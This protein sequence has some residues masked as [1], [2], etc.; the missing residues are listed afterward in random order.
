MV[1]LCEKSRD[2]DETWPSQPLL[3]SE[4]TWF[5]AV[6]N[7]IRID[8][9]TLKCK[10]TLRTHRYPS[11]MRDNVVQ[12]RC[13]DSWKCVQGLVEWSRSGLDHVLP[14]QIHS[15]KALRLWVVTINTREGTSLWV[16]QCLVCNNQIENNLTT[17]WLV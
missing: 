14:Q 11:Y 8:S 7:L 5:T 3:G 16:Q 15:L 17:V 1:Y 2:N 4:I 12:Y 6:D 9:A 13:R 10:E